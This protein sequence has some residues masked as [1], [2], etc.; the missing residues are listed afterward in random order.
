MPEKTESACPIIFFNIIVQKFSPR[1]LPQNLVWV[2]G[3]GSYAYLC[4]PV[5]G[6]RV[7][8]QTL[9]GAGD[10]LLVVGVG[11]MGGDEAGKERRREGEEGG[12]KHFSAVGQLV[13][14]N[15][16]EGFRKH[17]GRVWRVE[18]RAR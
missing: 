2:D 3:G 8:P 7:V 11:I 16:R 1:Q 9:V 10:G 18:R 14:N 6:E 17:E 5:A 12:G 4:A 15:G 13:D